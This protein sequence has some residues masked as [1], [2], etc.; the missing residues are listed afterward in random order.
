MMDIW[1]ETFHPFSS[2]L[3][4]WDAGTH[5]EKLKKFNFVINE[6]ECYDNKAITIE[7]SNPLEAFELMEK[8]NDIEYPP[9]VE[10]Y[11]KGSKLSDNI[12]SSN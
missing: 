11:D 12:E 1:I 7:L 5:L 2:V 8:I 10:V 6:V 3:V 4:I 9:V